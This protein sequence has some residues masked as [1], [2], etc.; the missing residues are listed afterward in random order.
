M[1]QLFLIRDRSGHVFN[2]TKNPTVIFDK[3]EGVVIKIGDYN[4][5]VEYY[6][7][8]CN[9]YNDHGFHFMA[10]DLVLMELPKDQAEIDKVCTITSYI[11][12][13]YEQTQS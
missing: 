5:M 4:T 12:T 2:K 11:K 7:F 6:N 1:N 8:I 10:D 3:K 9:V 13:L